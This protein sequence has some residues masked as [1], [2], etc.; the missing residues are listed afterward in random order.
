MDNVTLIG[1]SMTILSV[2]TFICYKKGWTPV[3]KF[4][5]HENC[6]ENKF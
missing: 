3:Y 2:I 4:L 1:I 5:W 6:I